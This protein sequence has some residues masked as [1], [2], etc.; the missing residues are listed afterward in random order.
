MKLSVDF[1]SKLIEVSAAKYANTA[2]SPSA[3]VSL[4]PRAIFNFKIHFPL[5]YWVTKKK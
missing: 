3:I 4:P 1:Q 5:R 2:P